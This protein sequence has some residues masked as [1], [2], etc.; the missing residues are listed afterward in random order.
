MHIV[1]VAEMRELEA[2]A[3][4]QYGLTSPILMQHAGKSAAD[5]FEAHLP[6]HQNLKDLKV[7]CLIG[8]GNNGGDGKVMA[9]HL[10][11]HGALISL[12]YWKERKL[13]VRG[14]D[15]SFTET[16]TELESQIQ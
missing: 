4:Q 12:Y 10:A 15:T 3:E 7:L 6:P 16:A 11:Q 5:L 14:W 1:T 9:G 8:P 13:T 2:Q